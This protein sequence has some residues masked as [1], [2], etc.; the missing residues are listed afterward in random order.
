MTEK[1]FFSLYLP[2]LE[3]AL[4]HDHE[5]HGFHVMCPSF[6]VP[7]E[8]SLELEIF[9]D[10][11]KNDFIDMVEEYFF[12]LSHYEDNWRGIGINVVRDM[13][14]NRMNELKLMI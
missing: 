11:L 3:Q 4:A 2:A 6:F 12:A 9:T 14:I 13:I 8:H 10:I 7:K 1:E 5:N